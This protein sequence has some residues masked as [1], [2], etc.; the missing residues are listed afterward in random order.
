M[1][2]PP[3]SPRA[4]YLY[5]WRLSHSLSFPSIIIINGMVPKQNLF[6]NNNLKS[7]SLFYFI[8]PLLTF[9]VH[10]HVHVFVEVQSSSATRV[11]LS[12]DD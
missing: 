10:V 2:F 9:S 11:V 12:A 3:P 5:Q 4:R 6:D 1:G 8:F 7:L